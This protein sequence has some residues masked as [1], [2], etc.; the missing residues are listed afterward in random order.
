[1]QISIKNDH[2]F[3]AKSAQASIIFRILVKNCHKNN[4]FKFFLNR[5]FQCYTTSNIL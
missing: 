2:T 5:K 3:Q 4:D 1:M